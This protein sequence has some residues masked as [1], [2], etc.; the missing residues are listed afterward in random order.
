VLRFIFIPDGAEAS[1]DA[2]A[3]IASPIRIPATFVP[4]AA[5]AGTRAEPRPGWSETFAPQSGGAGA[6]PAFTGGVAATENVVAGIDGAQRRPAAYDWPAAASA[7]APIAS[8]GARAPGANPPMRTRPPA[9]ALAKAL[10]VFLDEKPDAPVPF[11]DDTG[12]GFVDRDQKPMM[13]PVGLDPHFFVRRGLQD[14]Q[15]ENTAIAQGGA[16]ALAALAYE[17]RQLSRFNRWKDWD[18]QRIGKKNHPEFVDYAT[19]A[20]G[21]YAAANGIPK[22][23]TLWMEDWIARNSV[24]KGGTVMDKTYTHLPV[25]NVKNTDLGYELYQSGRIAPDYRP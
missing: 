4:D 22:W 14:R 24:Y 9:P 23:Q 6:A 11:V 18:A 1:A 21:L 7:A 2:L 13:R 17:Y 3:Q 25:L 12:R 20:I 15:L 16:R 8:G 19:I 10:P 5:G